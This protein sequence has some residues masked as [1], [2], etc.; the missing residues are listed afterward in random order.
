M[1][2]SLQLLPWLLRY[3]PDGP[4]HELEDLLAHLG[5]ADI[6][7]RVGR[8]W[9]GVDR[10]WCHSDGTVSPPHEPEGT[11][12]DCILQR[13]KNIKF[14]FELHT[15]KGFPAALYRCMR[16]PLPWGPNIPWLPSLMEATNSSM[17]FKVDAE[18]RL[19]P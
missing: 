6:K 17:S 11:S 1:W 4:A 5:P 10:P 12:S 13:S 16:P 9:L 7:V 18:P 3:L 14:E 19:S 8:L 15:S 2:V